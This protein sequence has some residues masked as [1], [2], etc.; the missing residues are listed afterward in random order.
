[1]KKLAWLLTFGILLVG[2]AA[3]S[4]KTEDPT[5]ER[6]SGDPAT[7]ESTPDDSSTQ[8]DGGSEHPSPEHPK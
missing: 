6:S 5:P 4:G 7:T 3:C 1:M 8:D 2:L